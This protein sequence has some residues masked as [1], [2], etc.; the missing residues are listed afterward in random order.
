MLIAVWNSES[1]LWLAVGSLLGCIFCYLWTQRQQ[2]IWQQD[3]ASL[4]QQAKDEA[5]ALLSNAAQ[6]AQSETQA[7]MAK[8]ENEINSLRSDLA[9]KESRINERESLINRQL[10][11][12]VKQEQMV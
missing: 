9:N 3:K 2:R 6:N 5:E 10:E 4:L 8:T 11:G 7:L 12:L 1:P